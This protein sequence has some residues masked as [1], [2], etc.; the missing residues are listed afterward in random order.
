M[1]LVEKIVYL[2]DYIDDSRSFEDC[3]KLREIF[4]SADLLGMSDSEREIHLSK[5]L[6]TSYDMT[7]AALIAD[8]AP[9]SEDT[10]KARNS[11]I[12]EL[13]GEVN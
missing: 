13:C 11:L 3:V 1:S 5:T 12:V 2:A 6:I 8:N 9:I 7:L 10:F 4:W